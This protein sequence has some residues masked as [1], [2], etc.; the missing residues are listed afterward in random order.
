MMPCPR[1]P[2]ELLLRLFTEPTRFRIRVINPEDGYA[3]DATT[4]ALPA[5]DRSRGGPIRS[6]QNTQDAKSKTV[7]TIVRNRKR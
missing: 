2:L 1:D 5:R 6:R 3:A 7:R 4:F